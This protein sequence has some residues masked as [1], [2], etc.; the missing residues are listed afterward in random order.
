MVGRLPGFCAEQCVWTALLC[1]LTM[2][3]VRLSGPARPPRKCSEGTTRLNGARACAG[4]DGAV[5]LNLRG[6]GAYALLLC[7]DGQLT[8]AELQLH[9]GAAPQQELRQQPP[10][11][12]GPTSCCATGRRSSCAPCR[13]LTKLG[14]GFFRDKHYEHLV[15]VPVIRAGGAAA[16][17]RD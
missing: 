8:R 2:G 4:A 1:S 15:H 11:A 14:K 10:S 3:Q 16:E 17:R 7:A 5:V 6:P 12:R 9:L 13:A